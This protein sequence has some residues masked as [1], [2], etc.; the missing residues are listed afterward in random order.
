MC[1]TRS[2]R[3][4]RRHSK[5]DAPGDRLWSPTRRKG[6]RYGAFGGTCGRHEPPGGCMTNEQIKEFRKRV[7]ADD[8][9]TRDE[10]L[11]ILQQLYRANRRVQAASKAGFST[12][13]AKKP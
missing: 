8:L 11:Y 1:W 12:E 4:S 5:R 3:A 9:L 2:C 6:C 13:P 10:Q 7:E